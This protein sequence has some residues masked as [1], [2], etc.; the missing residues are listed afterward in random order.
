MANQ[1]TVTSILGP[2]QAITTKVFSNLSAIDF[3]LATGIISLTSN[4]VITQVSYSPVTR[5]TFSISG[6]NTTIA[7]T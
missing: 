1:A 5:V 2:G 6:G 4:G 3:Q 7:I